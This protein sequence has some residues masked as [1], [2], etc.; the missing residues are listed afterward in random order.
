MEVYSLPKFLTCKEAAAAASCSE[1]TIKRA[2]QAGQ[3]IA[4]RPGRSYQ[5]DENDLI[6]WIKGKKVN[7]KQKSE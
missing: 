3:L 5:I 4:Y 1:L 6:A 2:V 7:P